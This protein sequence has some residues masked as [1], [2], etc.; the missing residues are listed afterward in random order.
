MTKAKANLAI[1]PQIC[2]W[3][4]RGH[5]TDTR[6]F[7]E[8]QAEK[9]QEERVKHQIDSLDPVFHNDSQTM[10]QLKVMAN[11]ARDVGLLPGGS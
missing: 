3:F 11:F 6:I 10:E 7:T 4:K 5:K 9:I 8:C 2:R 1:E